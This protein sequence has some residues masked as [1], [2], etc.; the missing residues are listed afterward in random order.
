MIKSS[1]DKRSEKV[2]RILKIQGNSKYCK[3]HGYSN[4]KDLHFGPIC[5]ILQK[6]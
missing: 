3:I 4:C 2:A 5:P 1:N 6:S